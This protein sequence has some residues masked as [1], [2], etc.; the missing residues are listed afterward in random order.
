[1]KKFITTIALVTAMALPAFAEGDDPSAKQGEPK[2]SGAKA[3]T[4]A[5][6]DA[7]S[8]AMGQGRVIQRST[9]GAASSSDNQLNKQENSSTNNPGQ[10][11]GV[12]SGGDGSGGGSGGSGG[13][14]G[15][16]GN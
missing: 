9:T 5:K 6:Q 3:S 8:S 12:T 10:K 1:M 15:G 13:S 14:G 4:D 2:S 16:S 11:T 7:G